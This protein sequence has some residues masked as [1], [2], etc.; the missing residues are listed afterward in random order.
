[1]TINANEGKRAIR[2][3]ETVTCKTCGARVKLEDGKAVEVC[4]GNFERT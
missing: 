1:M 4:C 2:T 3:N